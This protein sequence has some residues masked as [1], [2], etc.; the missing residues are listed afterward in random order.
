MSEK[1]DHPNV[2]ERAVCVYATLQTEQGNERLLE[3][4]E[5]V[6]GANIELCHLMVVGRHTPV[7][8]TLIGSG[9]VEMLIAQVNLF[10]PT[11]IIFSQNL[12]PAQSRNLEKMCCCRVI[13]RTELILDIFAQRARTFEGRLQVELAQL[14]HLSTRLIRGWTHLE[15]QRGGIGLRGP[16]ETQ[17]EID[18]RLIGGRIKSIQARLAKVASQ[19]EQARRRRMRS[20]TPSVALVGYTN[21]GKSTLFNA[22]SDAQVVAEDRLFATLDPTYRACELPGSSDAV[23]ID[24][25]GFIH[26]LPPD[27]VVAFKA[28][29][30]EATRAQLLCHVVDVTNAN[31]A[32]LESDVQWVL[33]EINADRVPQLMVYNKI[34]ADADIKPRI[35]RDEVGVPWRVWVSAQT[36][37]GMD[38]LREAMAEC[39]YEVY[40]EQIIVLGPDEG[41][42][43]AHYYALKAV[44]EEEALEKG[45]WRMRVYLPKDSS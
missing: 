37:L 4:Q 29:L 2:I 25:V 42:R 35:D 20:A 40:E 1:K 27:L 11:V 14:R 12:T 23:I 16:G 34:D 26:D 43:R 9:K 17:L 15:R 36:G 41:K 28:T 33:T 13:D 10:K 45:G 22:L 8:R 24:T 21:A 3:F 6:R 32:A 19:R 30:E 18:R 38:L 7:A 31:R 5:L 39:L 44:R